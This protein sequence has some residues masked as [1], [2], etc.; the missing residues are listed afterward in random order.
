MHLAGECTDICVLHTAVDAYNKG[1]RIVVHQNAVASCDPN[2][3][4]WALSH[5]KN[6]L[7]ASVM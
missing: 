7:G 6:V 3:H 1:F 2:S 4:A 5:F